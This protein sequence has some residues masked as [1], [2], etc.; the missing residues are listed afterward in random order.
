M[1]E[2]APTKVLD[3]AP[4][5][6]AKDKNDQPILMIDVRASDFYALT[7]INILKMEDYQHIPFLMFVNSHAIRIFK[8]T[9]FTEVLRLNTRETLKFYAHQ[10]TKDRISTSFVMRLIQAWLRDLA[11]HW[12]SEIPPQMEAIKQIGLLDYLANGTT[13]ELEEN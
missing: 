1:L 2:I 12:K 9:N 13:R 5:I 3:F 11:Y 8:T 7:D 6:V 4:S 10:V